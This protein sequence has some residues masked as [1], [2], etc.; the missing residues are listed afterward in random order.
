MAKSKCKNEK[1]ENY[2]FRNKKRL[3]LRVI[4]GRGRRT[5]KRKNKTIRNMLSIIS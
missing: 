3:Q 2:L 5:K 4:K 1:D